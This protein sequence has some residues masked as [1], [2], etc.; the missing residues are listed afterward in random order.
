MLFLR[1]IIKKHWDEKGSYI[2]FYLSSNEFLWFSEH[3]NN[4]LL[5]IN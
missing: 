1:M 2:L 3:S 5:H 4:L